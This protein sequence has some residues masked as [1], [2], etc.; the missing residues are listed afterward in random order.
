M[1]NLVEIARIV[2]PH[3]LKGR[4]C[5]KALGG[6]NSALSRYSRFIVGGSGTPRRVVSLETKKTRAVVLLEGFDH[7]SQV[8]SLKGEILYV[9]REDL[10]EPQEGEY[11][12]RDL[13]GLEVFDAGGRSLGQVVGL[14]PTGSNDVLVV[15]GDRQHLIPFTS[16]VILEV[17]L[18][19]RR[20]VIDASLLEDVLDGA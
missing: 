13:V 2:G 4:M 7:I 8:E 20:I 10:P 9:P 14:I 1:A 19:L 12:W 18:S 6:D 11:Y 15:D 3:G 16:D 17:C 5:V